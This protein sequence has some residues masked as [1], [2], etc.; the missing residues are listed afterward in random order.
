MWLLWWVYFVK[1]LLCHSLHLVLR[2]LTRQQ[3]LTHG[4]KTCLRLHWAFL[5]TCSSSE[6][7]IF[8]LWCYIF[9][10]QVCFLFICMLVSYT[11]F[12]HNYNL[13]QNHNIAFTWQVHCCIWLV[14]LSRNH[15]VLSNTII[16]WLRSE[17]SY[18]WVRYLHFLQ[19]LIFLN[20]PSLKSLD[21]QSLFQFHYS[22]RT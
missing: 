21:L 19:V 22:Q 11:V 6:A 13:T 8:L 10:S 18:L 12:Q 20:S 9:C 5:Q 7:D 1:S 4:K 3:C 14:P 2:D 16:T 15:W 17:K